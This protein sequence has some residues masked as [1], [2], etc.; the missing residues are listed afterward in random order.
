M[1]IFFSVIIP[2]YNK[3]QD[4]ENTIKS[5][6]DQTYKQ[7]EI[8]VVNDGSTD[9]GEDVVRQFIDDRIKLFSIKNSG[10]SVARNY[11]VQVST[12]DYVAFLD[13][14][15]YWYPCHLQNLNSL[16]NNFPKGKWFANAFEIEH[17]KRLILAME[18]PVMKLK[19]GWVGEVD[20]FFKNSLKDCMVCSSS[21]CVK[22][23]FYHEL[24]GFNVA[25]ENGEDVD[26][27]IRAGIKEKL[28]F[29]NIVTARYIFSA[30]NRISTKNIL[31]RTIVDF[32]IYEKEARVD[33]WLKRYLDLNRYSVAIQFKM[34]NN[35]KFFKKY[36]SEIQLRNLT[37]KQ[38]FLLRQ[39][40]WV[41]RFLS[42]IKSLLERVKLRIRT[43]N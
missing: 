12:G 6:L 28:Y 16:I 18:T 19:M 23:D 1:E 22:K 42:Q 35:Y 37:Y 20:N 33:I 40:S 11:G 43:S 21:V 2:L 24:G 9:A 30:S 38:R 14:D 5:V 31:E 15:D 17:N 34:N 10:V 32:D 3:E 7:F 41:L 27:W 13:A 8:V 25:Y 4:I 29:S 36:L 26:L 39:P